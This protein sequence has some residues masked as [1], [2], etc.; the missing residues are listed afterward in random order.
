[1][2][3]RPKPRKPSSTHPKLDCAARIV[4]IAL[5]VVFGLGAVA[6]SLYGRDGTMHFVYGCLGLAVIANKGNIKDV[7]EHWRKAK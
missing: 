5:A 3:S 2:P 4:A 7:L 1:M 6:A